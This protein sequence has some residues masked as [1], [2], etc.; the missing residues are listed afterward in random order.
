MRGK[1]SQVFT[2]TN[3]V[4]SWTTSGGTLSATGPAGATWTAP[5]AGGTFTVT[6]TNGDGEDVVTITVK[7]VVPFNPSKG[8]QVTNKKKVLLFVPDD[9]PRQTSTK[10]PSK[11]TF[12]FVCNV[13][14]KAEF[15]EMFAFWDWNYPGQTVYLT[16]PGTGI[17]SLYWID[18]DLKEQW[19]FTNLM[20]YSF[21]ATEA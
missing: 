10:G 7:A 12:E 15:L 5:N 3:G 21:V 20:G 18:S 17:E 2:A 6:A 13:R 8:Y 1:A 16:H 11:R 4:D 19:D 9:G 14:Q